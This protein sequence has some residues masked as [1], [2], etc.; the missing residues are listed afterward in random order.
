MQITAISS[1]SLIPALL[2]KQAA[3]IESIGDTLKPRE[4]SLFDANTLLYPLSDIKWAVIQLRQ[5]EDSDLGSK[6]YLQFPNPWL[7]AFVQHIVSPADN[8]DEKV[9]KIEQ[10]VKGNI[11]YV[12]HTEN[13]GTPELWAFPLVTLKRSEGG[14]EDGA[15]LIHS[16][17]LHAG[18][19]ADRLRTYG[20]FVIADE[21]S[22]TTAGHA[23]T[24]YRR[25]M[26]D[27]WIVVDWCYW[28]KDTLLSERIPMS[29]DHKYID[30]YFF[31]EAG[32]TVDTPT[33]SRVPY[34]MLAKGVLVNT[35]V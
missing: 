6:E 29:D 11:R 31:V 19:P 20:G 10:W 1:Q 28:A 3:K 14:S 12:S 26:D 22:L 9:Y 4:S 18:V 34:A 32:S 2:P 25:Q 21:L 17:A 16:L 15:Y 23:W 24:A 5:H 13:Y 33:T 27:R 30:D 35:V 7:Q 8:N